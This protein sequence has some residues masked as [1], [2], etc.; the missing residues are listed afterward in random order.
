M[1]NED[2]ILLTN[3]PCTNNNKDCKGCVNSIK[4]CNR[5][6][7]MGELRFDENFRSENELFDRLQFQEK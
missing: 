1:K 2:K 5:S 7:V 6:K 4:N 3:S